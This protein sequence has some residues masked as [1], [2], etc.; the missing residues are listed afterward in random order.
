MRTAITLFTRDLRVHDNPALRAAAEQ[1]EQVVPLFVLDDALL[2]RFGAPNRVSF[3]LESLAD[4]RES[5]AEIGAPLVVRQ[6]EPIREVARVA[7]QTGAEAV[8]I[9]AD[10]SAY[11]QRRVRRLREL[12][13]A[14]HESPGV[15]V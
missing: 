3:L 14:V 9:A 12:R 1:A 11:S 4:L 7:E 5:L 6:G 2:G 8:F 13:L 10:V 15:T